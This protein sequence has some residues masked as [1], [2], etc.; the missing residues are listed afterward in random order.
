M[1]C[2][3]P[4]ELEGI[5]DALNPTLACAAAKIGDIEALEAISEMVCVILL[6]A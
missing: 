6:Y 4:K 2:W 1:W 5:R 3:F